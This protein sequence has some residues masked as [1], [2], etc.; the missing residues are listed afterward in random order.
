MPVQQ[1]DVLLN[2][3]S[4]KSLCVPMMQQPIWRGEEHQST[5]FG[6]PVLWWVTIW[7]AASSRIAT[8]SVALPVLSS[9]A[10]P[11]NHYLPPPPICGGACGHHTKQPPGAR[12]GAPRAGQAI[13]W[14]ACPGAPWLI[15]TPDSWLRENYWLE[16][17]MCMQGKAPP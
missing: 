16:V 5:G 6:F 7:Q 9:S 3:L 8:H 14:P 13:V 10:T 17:M 1:W 11:N 15:Q 4:N 12:R 2:T